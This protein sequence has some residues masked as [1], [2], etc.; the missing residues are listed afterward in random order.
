[1]KDYKYHYTYLIENLNP[2]NAHQFYVGVRSC[3]CSPDEDNY[4]GSSSVLDTA[5]KEQGI[6]NFSKLILN[7]F[8]SREEAEI[9]ENKIHVENKSATNPQFYNKKNGTVGWHV[10]EEAIHKLKEIKSDLT[11]KATTGKEA[12]RKKKET[13][14]DP[15]WV[16][17]KRKV[18]MRKMQDTKSDPT[19]L[20]TV[21]KELR[22]KQ[23]D[24]VSSPHWKETVGVEK[25]RKIKDTLHNP[26]WKETAGN[27]KIR[28]Y[29]ETVN[30]PE[31]VKNNTFECPHCGKSVNGNGN[32]N[33]W[34][35]N[36]CKHKIIA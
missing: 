7:E 29:K 24:T 26:A 9:N 14:S 21:G 10:T 31:W 5:I 4:M 34:H 6:A 32:F 16:A 25:I 2:T 15:K 11:W 18:M 36:N 35:N 13:I 22:R 17:G 20:K 8:K 19:W 1:M 23:K 12:I 28:K 3:D 30:D 27:E 33:R